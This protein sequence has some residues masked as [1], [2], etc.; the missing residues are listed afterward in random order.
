M[1]IVFCDECLKSNPPTVSDVNR[2]KET[3]Q[4]L[5][6]FHKYI[7]MTKTRKEK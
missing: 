7:D 2:C 4:T 5:Y 6:C 1:P 3:K